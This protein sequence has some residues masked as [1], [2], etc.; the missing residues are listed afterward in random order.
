MARKLQ[1]GMKVRVEEAAWTFLGR[2]RRRGDRVVC[3]QL[4]GDGDE[5][6]WYTAAE[7]RSLC[8]AARAKGA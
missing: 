6:R 4:Q 1:L 7:F 5:V 3:Y 2:K 8:G